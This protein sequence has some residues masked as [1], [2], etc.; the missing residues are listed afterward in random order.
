MQIRAFLQTIRVGNLTFCERKEFTMNKFSGL[1]I[2]IVAIGLSALFSCSKSSSSGTTTTGDTTVVVPPKDTVPSLATIRSWLVDKNASDE[3]AAL[4]YNLKTI[5]KKNIMFGQQ[6]ANIQGNDKGTGNWF[7]TSSSTY[8]RTDI[9]DVT[10]A[11]PAIY[12]ND[13]NFVASFDTTNPWFADQTVLLHN[14]TVSAYKAGGINTY[15]W[16]C[17][18]QVSKGDF[19]WDKSPVES[20]A[21]ILPGGNYNEVFKW[22]LRRVADFAKSCV[23]NG[24]AVPIIFRPWH[25]ADGNWFWWGTTHCTASDYK[26]LYQYT[27]IYLRDSLKVHNLLYAWSPGPYNTE[28][29]LMGLYPGDAY[30]DIIGCDNY[31]TSAASAVQ[32]LK[33]ISDY[34]IN[35]NKVAAFTETGLHNITQSDWYT[36]VLLKAMQT[37]KLEL[38]YA[39][40]WYDTKDDYW[41]P[42]KGHPAEGDFVKF[43]NDSYLMFGD[44]M[45]DVYHLK[46]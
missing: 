12:G 34:A 26:N 14:A 2:V 36:A 22:S 38:A 46:K 45:P 37:T 18:N 25:E 29:A 44:K 20:V 24:V 19:Y 31:F 13:F 9:K 32:P 17:A 4:F 1:N 7:A 28:M 40:V 43:K 10:G 15:S 3:I 27:V 39:M 21:E 23:V 33:V 5:A 6:G 35:K 8:D 11:A 42:Y 30:V 16:H 41:V